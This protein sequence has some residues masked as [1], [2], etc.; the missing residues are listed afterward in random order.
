MTARPDLAA[1]TDDALAAVAN[2]GLLKRALRMQST[3]PPTLSV[4]EDA[5][6]AHYADGVETILLAESAFTD[7]SCTC[8]ATGICRHLVGLVVAYRLLH[9]AAPST[10]WSPA[11]F[12]DGA[13]IAHLGASALRRAEKIRRTGYSA[14]VHRSRGDDPSV[15]VELPHS[16]V[17]FLVPHE[18]TLARSSASD[19]ATPESIALAVWAVREADARHNDTVHVGGSVMPESTTAGAALLLARTVLVDGV[20]HL[21]EVQYVALR[22]TVRS[23][24]AGT[25]VWLADACAELLD[26][27]EA[28]RSRHA[29]HSRIRAATVIAEIDARVRVG[30]SQDSSI[31]ATALGTNTPSETP[32]RKTRLIALGTHVTGTGPNIRADLYFAE[33]DSDTVH[34]LQTEWTEPSG[35]IPTG[36]ALSKRRVAGTTIEALASSTVVTESAVRQANHR[37]RLGRRGIG[38]TAIMPLSTDTWTK[39]LTVV[40]DYT[41]EYTRLAGRTPSVVSERILTRG[42]GVVHVESV[43]SKEYSSASQQLTIRVRD[44]RQTAA[45][46][47]VDYRSYAPRAMDA[48]DSCLST[49]PAA[50]AGRLSIRNGLLQISPFAIAGVGGVVVPDLEAPDTATSTLPTRT[51]L[52]QSAPN[53]AL[54]LLADLAHKGLRH[55]SATD[56][57]Y[58]RRSAVQLAGSGMTT[59]ASAL[60]RVADSVSGDIGDLLDAW[61]HALLRLAVAQEC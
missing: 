39:S 5:V 37:I 12:D 45:E 46:V 50:V 7:A 19:E 60:T 15:R 9:P 35:E 10:T 13:L 20:A 28:Y 14:T 30:R 61:L 38:R 55:A 21:T 3:E 49:G 44:E 34:L 59:T 8:E 24:Q 4:S 33:P 56:T 26:Q 18:L 16:T 54:E 36:H 25:A 57:T 51:D 11:E 43:L 2:R 27:V 40:N 52:L 58:L 47:V 31:A 17:R 6:V 1:L 23:I 48:V 42:V 32:L 53:T 22:R 29:G 41:A